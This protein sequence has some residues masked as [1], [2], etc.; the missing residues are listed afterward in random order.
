MILING[1]IGY[2]FSISLRSVQK[3]AHLHCV[4]ITAHNQIEIS[5]AR[6]LGGEPAGA[7]FVM[8]MSVGI[9]ENISQLNVTRMKTK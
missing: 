5:P 7:I 2:G 3:R 9:K 6:I 8:D 1:A 4:C